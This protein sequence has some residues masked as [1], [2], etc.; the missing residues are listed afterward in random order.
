MSEREFGE[1]FPG[2]SAAAPGL[3]SPPILPVDNILS[4]AQ[5]SSTERGNAWWIYILR[6]K[7]NAFLSEENQCI[8]YRWQSGHSPCHPLPIMPFAVMLT[9]EGD[10]GSVEK[11][12]VVMAMDCVTCLQKESAILGDRAV[13]HHLAQKDWL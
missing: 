1:T 4:A 12:D 9:D 2:L 13:H 11:A 10:G 6:D 3:K 8:V 7:A 5:K